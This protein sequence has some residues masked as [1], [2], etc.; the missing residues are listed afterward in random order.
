MIQRSRSLS[1]R[2]SPN[3]SKPELPNV[4]ERKAV[5]MLEAQFQESRRLEQEIWTQLPKMGYGN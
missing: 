5:Q 1:K 4:S 3:V 2:E